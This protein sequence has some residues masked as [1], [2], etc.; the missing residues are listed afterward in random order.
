MGTGMSPRLRVAEVRSFANETGEVYRVHRVPFERVRGGH[1][2]RL[3]A[4]VFKELDGRWVGS[5]P[6]YHTVRLPDLTEVDLSESFE[7][8]IGRGGT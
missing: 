2:P 6:L 8:A 1:E 3:C 4:L 7:Q 5:V